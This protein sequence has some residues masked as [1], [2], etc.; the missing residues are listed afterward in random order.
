MAPGVTL[1]RVDGHQPVSAIFQKVGC[2]PFS[3][4]RGPMKMANGLASESGRAALRAP[5]SG[6]ALWILLVAMPTAAQESTDARALLRRAHAL[7]TEP[8]RAVRVEGHREH[9]LLE[10][11]KLQTRI[12]DAAGAKKSLLGIGKRPDRSLDPVWLE[13]VRCLA[14]SNRVGEARALAVELGRRACIAGLLHI[15]KTQWDRGDLEK[16]LETVELAEQKANGA[17]AGLNKALALIRSAGV[18]SHFGS[19]ARANG[20]IEK[21]LAAPGLSKNTYGRILV[22]TEIACLDARA[23]KRAGASREFSRA[24]ELAPRI[25]G[26][27]AREQRG[28]ALSRIAISQARVGYLD[29]A[30]KTAKLIPQDDFPERGEA[31]YAIGLQHLRRG[32]LDTA[33]EVAEGVKYGTVKDTLL[34]KAVRAHAEKRAFGEA[35]RVARLVSHRSRRADA[36]LTVAWLQAI[37]GDKAAAART[38]EG[39]SLTDQVFSEKVL[40]V[41]PPHV[42]ALESPRTWGHWYDARGGGMLILID[43]ERAAAGVAAAAMRLHM[44]LGRP[45]GKFHKDFDRCSPLVL[46]ALARAH[47]GSR[48]PAEAMLWVSRIEPLQERIWSILGLAEA[49]AD[50]KQRGAEGVPGT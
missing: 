44:A 46:R 36:L 17:R 41:K 33:V 26:K 5:W 23:G 18:L 43:A 20:A 16:A 45:A 22:A 7:A 14:E 50:R 10:I 2:P 12:G 3:L 13:V 40:G 37:S 24:I 32:S 28:I 47:A 1:T 49:A 15:A 19:K 27:Y 34:L 39:I 30:L 11:A 48:S 8:R 25:Q 9:D 4:P 38:A 31:V 6:P 42:F 35:L 29:A 21:A